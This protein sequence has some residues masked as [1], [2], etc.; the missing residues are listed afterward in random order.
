MNWLF[1]FLTILN[2]QHNPSS[3]DFVWK[4]RVF[5]YTGEEDFSGWLSEELN[6]DLTERK[7]LF[8]Y[9]Q[10]NE[11]VNTNYKE[12][13]EIELFRKKMDINMNSSR[14]WVLI[15]LDGDV[16][17]SGT[18]LPRPQEIFNRID[19]MPMR[20]SELVKKDNQDNSSNK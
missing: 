9:F 4:Y 14:K 2:L 10:K 19:A 13:L 3:E 6:Q 17:N 16:K 11:L 12:N 5:I 18:N 7:L 15:G 1:N 20:Q 8:F